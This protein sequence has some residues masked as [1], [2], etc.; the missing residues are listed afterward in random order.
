VRCAVQVQNQ[1]F[2]AG[3]FRQPTDDFLIFPTPLGVGVNRE[4][5]ITEIKTVAYTSNKK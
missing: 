2:N 3:F 4:I 1:N 5:G